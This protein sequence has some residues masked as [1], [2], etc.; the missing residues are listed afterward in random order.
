[1]ATTLLIPGLNGSS[2]DHWQRHWADD[3][4]E[5]LVVEQDDWACP[6]LHHWQA[7]LDDALSKTDGAFLV[8]HSLGCLLI[9]SY[10]R[11]REAN[12]VLG[13]LLVA[14]CDLPTAIRRHPCMIDFGEAPLDALPFPSLVVGSLDDPYM[15]LDQ[16]ERHGHAWGSDLTTLGFAGHINVA[17][18]YG[19]WEQ[20]YELFD[21]L[22]R[23]AGRP[24]TTA[25]SPAE[26]L[27]GFTTQRRAG[28][29]HAG[30]P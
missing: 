16:L 1:M 29:R 17:S 3:R 15:D 24:G 20:G 23:K 6:R 19:R 7:R 30:N 26:S 2:D 14:P 25:Q 22:L 11:R 8:G 5:A 9:A 18:G 10:A 12:R 4:R 27:P 21:R 28:A 13:A